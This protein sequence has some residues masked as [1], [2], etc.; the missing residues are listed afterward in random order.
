MNISARFTSGRDKMKLLMLAA[1][2]ALRTS[3]SVT[4]LNR[5]PYFIFSE[6]NL[7]LLVSYFYF[8]DKYR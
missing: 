8:I 5:A 2:A 1:I 6:K 4:F 7:S 3:S